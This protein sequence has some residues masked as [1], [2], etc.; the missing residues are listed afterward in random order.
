MAKTFKLPAQT[1][2]PDKLSFCVT[3]G[4]INSLCNSV[5]PSCHSLGSSP[6]ISEHSSTQA[7]EGYGADI[8]VEEDR[9]ERKFHCTGVLV[10]IGRIGRHS[11]IIE[12]KSHRLGPLEY[13]LG[14]AAL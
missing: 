5:Y 8:L 4:K 2:F 12:E 1:G 10:G 9:I 7:G 3:E 13:V 6:N 14:Q 11:G